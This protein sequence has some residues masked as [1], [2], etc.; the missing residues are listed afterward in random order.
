VLAII[1][2]LVIGDQPKVGDSSTDIA[3]FYTDH[4]SRVLTAMAASAW[5]RPWP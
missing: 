1:G 4:R 5:S 2:F 3:S